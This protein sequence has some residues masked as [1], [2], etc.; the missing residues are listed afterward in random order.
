[1][2]PYDV[3]LLNQELQVLYQ[4]MT[5]SDDFVPYDTNENK[6]NIVTAD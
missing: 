5:H 4:L 1:M 3:K 2:I 6:Y